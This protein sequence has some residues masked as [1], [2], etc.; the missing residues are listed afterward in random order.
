[1]SISLFFWGLHTPHRCVLPRYCLKLNSSLF[2]ALLLSLALTHSYILIHP[3]FIQ[4]VLLFPIIS[5]FNLCQIV[6]MKMFP[7]YYY[8]YYYFILSWW[9]SCTTWPGSFRQLTLFRFL[10]LRF[11]HML[12]FN[13]HSSFENSQFWKCVYLSRNNEWWSIARPEQLIAMLLKAIHKL[14]LLTLNWGG[15]WS[16]LYYHLHLS[17]SHIL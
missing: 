2:V 17:I 11:G 14:I 7:S 1:M 6:S 3:G 5:F 13:W 8:Y 9:C 16:I 10:S 15:V 12:S 4:F